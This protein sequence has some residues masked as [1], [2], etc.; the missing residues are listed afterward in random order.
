VQQDDVI[1]FLLKRQPFSERETETLRKASADLGFRVLYAPAAP[2][3][4]V[5]SGPIQSKPAAAITD[6][7][8]QLVLAADRR[9]FYAG[10]EKD[11]R[12]TTDDRPFFFH[13]AKLKD[14][15]GVVFGRSMLF[16]NGL[17]ALM[18]LTIISFA[19][20][21]LFVVA[22]LAVTG[23]P[24]V[25]GWGNWLVYFGALGAGFMLIEVS[26]LQRFVL[27]LGHPVYSLT[28]TLFS[29]LLG[30]GLGAMVSRVLPTQTLRRSTAIALLLVAAIAIVIV[31]VVTPV[32]AWA[33]PFS[34]PVRILVSVALLLPVGIVLGV[35]MP[36]GLRLLST[37]APQLVTWAWGMNGALSVVGATLAIFVAMNWGFRVTLLAAS[38]TYV[39]GLLALLAA[40]EE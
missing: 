13:S 25:A 36:A 23:V 11:I 31:L 19:L 38:S 12:P 1:T 34:R 8:P 35:P 20:V 15:V 30:T 26:V 17:S 5:T 22:P 29:L 40:V 39:I 18:T 33:I 4:P 32:I 10:Y 9:Q 16:G 37:R 2:G 27:L 6:A 7:Y 28:V 3:A 14:Q 24:D 21:A